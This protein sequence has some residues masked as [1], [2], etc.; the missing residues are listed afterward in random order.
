MS[1]LSYLIWNA[2]PTLVTLPF[3]KLGFADRELRWYG[4][5]FACGFLLAFY[6]FSYL[7]KKD[8]GYGKL[9]NTDEVLNYAVIATIVGARLGHCLFYNPTYY[10]ANPVE[11]LKIWKGGL[12]SHGAAFAIL[13]AMW[14]YSKYLIKI[15]FTF[16]V[17]TRLSIKLKPKDSERFLWVLDRACIVIVL[18]GI[19]I[20]TG[21]L[22]NSEMIGTPTTGGGGVLYA[23]GA[24]EVLHYDPGVVER[25]SFRK[26]RMQQG[27]PASL[28]PITAIVQYKPGVTLELIDSV[29]VRQHLSHRLSSSRVSENIEFNLDKEGESK[30]LQRGG[31]VYLELAGT[32]QLRHLGQMYEAISC[33]LLFILLGVGWRYFRH[34]LP[35][36][37]LFSIKL[38]VLW[39]VR[40]LIEFFKEDQEP[41]EADLILNMGQVLSIPLIVG[42]L[43]LLVI[44]SRKFPVRG[45]LAASGSPT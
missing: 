15:R 14:I 16:I 25:V 7:V 31:Q 40:F 4:L 30:F 42:G 17:P 19:F 12:A 45:P 39:S 35:V 10:L 11:I 24:Y 36:G 29:R 37:F 18:A 1:L 3:S 38:V 27:A 22:F 32:G 13:L 44:A 8:K 2:D 28:V 34:R 26:G 41:F 5:L 21:N 20:R 43:V 33:V 9:V 23:R 6:I